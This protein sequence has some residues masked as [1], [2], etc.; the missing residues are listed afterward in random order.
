MIEVEIRGRLTESQYEELKKYLEE[1]GTFQKH[2]EREMYLL[3]GYPGYDAGF[4]GRDMDIRLRNTNGECEIMVK[5][6]IGDGIAGREE[7]QLRLQ[8]THLDTAKKV[9]AALGYTSAKKMVRTMDLYKYEGID[10]QVVATPKGLWYYEAELEAANGEEV[11][12]ITK[13]LHAAAGE[14]Q[15]PIMSDEELDEFINIL[16]KE[17]NEDVEFE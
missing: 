6:K 3:R 17:V 7:I 9:V 12:E 10:W 14:L 5:R 2:S 8:D 11:S 1:R 15:L 13:K 4:A 16:D